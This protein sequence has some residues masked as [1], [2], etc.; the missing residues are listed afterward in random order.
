MFLKRPS[1]ATLATLATLFASGCII[2]GADDDG[3]SDTEVTTSPTTDPTTTP[4]TDPTTGAETDPT[5]VGETD[6]TTDGTTGEPGAAGCGWGPIAG[7]DEVPNGYQCGIEDGT[8]DP[9]GGFPIDCSPNAN[10]E[11][12]LDCTE[13]GVTAEGC[14]DANGDVWFCVDPDGA[15]G[16]MEPQVG[17][18]DCGDPTGTDTDTDT[19]ATDTDT[20]TDTDSGVD[21]NETATDGATDGATDSAGGSSSTTTGK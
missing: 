11:L 13:A 1:L 12:G 5:T 17:G 7:N 6:P 21:T 20:D 15:D 14:C 3:G 16:P 2:S 10:L 19:D 9:D 8:E 18:D 4:T